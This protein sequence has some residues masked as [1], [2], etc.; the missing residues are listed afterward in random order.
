MKATHITYENKT[1]KQIAQMVLVALKNLTDTDQGTI[2][3]PVNESSIVLDN[4]NTLIET[5]KTDGFIRFNDG[6][7]IVEC[8]DY[9][10]YVD[11]TSKALLEWNLPTDYKY[12]TNIN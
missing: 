3:N 6:Y 11:Y 10:L 5:I 8:D 4:K 2:S 7:M 9:C 1:Y 12:R